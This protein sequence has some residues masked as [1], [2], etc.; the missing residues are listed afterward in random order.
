MKAFTVLIINIIILL[1]VVGVCMKLMDIMVDR[2]WNKGREEGVG[3]GY[4]RCLQDYA[5]PI[6]IQTNI[7]FVGQRYGSIHNTPW[8]QWTI[9]QKMYLCAFGSSGNKFNDRDMQKIKEKYY[10]GE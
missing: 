4:N 8:D 3:V 10:A 9:Q 5:G 2:A 7:Q 1:I 6:S